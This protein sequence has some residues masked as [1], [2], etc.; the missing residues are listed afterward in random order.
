MSTT[1]TFLAL[2][3][4]SCLIQ[5]AVLIPFEQTEQIPGA[6]VSTPEQPPEQPSVAEAAGGFELIILHNND[7]HAR[8]QETDAMSKMCSK[9]DIM[10]NKCYGGF[11]RVVYKW[12]FFYILCYVLCFVFLFKLS[13]SDK[14]N[15]ST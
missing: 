13:F 7:M 6:V 4:V 11:A 10:L 12:V 15:K 14:H 9:E 2:I 3:F 5:P 8:F 1:N